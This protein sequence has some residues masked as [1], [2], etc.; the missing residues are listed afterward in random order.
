M[1]TCTKCKEEKELSE[2]NKQRKYLTSKCKH[3][4]REYRQSDAGKEYQKQY[5]KKYHQTDAYKEAQKR[6]I[7]TDA[8]KE[9]EKKYRQTD[10]CKEA[11]KKHHQSDA[12]KKRVEKYHKTDAYKEAKKRGTKK[13]MNTEKYF[14]K[15]LNGKG[16]KENDITPELIE[17]QELLIVTYRYTQQLNQVKQ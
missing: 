16:F 17:L 8:R 6:H 13:Y 5:Q 4:L 9:Y 14:K 11:Q 3:C 2:F 7:K 10:A 15:R 1:R 12:C